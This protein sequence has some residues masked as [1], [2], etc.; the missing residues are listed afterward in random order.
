VA[1]SQTISVSPAGSYTF[2]VVAG[3][4]PSG[5]TLNATTG[6]LSGTPAV[7]GTYNFT[8]KAQAANGC[9]ATQA[10]TLQITCPTITLNPASLPSGTTGTAYNQTVSATPAGGNYTYA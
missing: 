7:T 1:Y 4:L 10:Y 5:L 2:S 8:V 6:V 3:S 9:N